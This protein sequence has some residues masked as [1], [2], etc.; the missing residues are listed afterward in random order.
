[1]KHVKK[2]DDFMKNT[3]N[4]NQSRIDTLTT[5]VDV[6]DRFLKNDELF[7]EIYIETGLQGS[8]AHRTIIKPSPKSP[9]FDADLMLYVNENEEWVPKDYIE[10]L[11]KRFK[12]NSNYK[13]IVGRRTRCVTLDYSGEFHMD[14]VP[15]I[16]RESL[17]S[18]KTYHVCNRNDNVEELTDTKGYTEW[19]LDKNRQVGNNYLIKT[20][21]L[22]KYLRDIKQTFSCKSIL[23]TT[24]LAN[25]VVGFGDLFEDY[26]D[27]PTTL[28]IVVNNLN[29]YLQ[30]NAVMPVVSNPVNDDEN[31]NRHW[32]QEKYSNFRAQIK[33][34]ND[35]I[36][37]A[38]DEA[39]QA[40]SIKKW[41]KIFGDEFDKAVANKS[42]SIAESR[43]TQSPAYPTPAHVEPPPWKVLSGIINPKIRVTI[44]RAND[45][46]PAIAE[47]GTTVGQPVGR[48][49][50]VRMEYLGGVSPGFSLYWQIVNTGDEARAAGDLRGKIFYGGNVRWEDTRY[51]G[52]HWIECFIVD[53]KKKICTG[54]SGRYF[55]NVG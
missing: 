29:A 25:Q 48:N 16:V 4:L 39:D 43:A 30:D 36:N 54:R 35:W 22:I 19:F 12:A 6:I 18:G 37:D 52:V 17:W 5:H 55:V 40:E 14:V 31:F 10:E 13:N 8:Y 26:D 44:H 49:L 53:D 38:Y 27:L 2:F 1:M 42:A 23:L 9:E 11:Y 32:D 50:K 21:R 33:K 45:G 3:V 20:V 41:Q 46:S 34:Y 15:C 47:M 24:F 28:K 7:K 51:R